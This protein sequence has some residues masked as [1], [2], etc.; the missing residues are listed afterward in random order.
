MIV[1]RFNQWEEF[2][3]E[4]KESPPEGETV[5]LTWNLRYD[6]QG[7]PHLSM[8][9]GYHSGNT[10]VEFV[11]Y[12]GLEPRDRN[13]TRAREIQELFDRRKRCLEALGLRVKPGRYHAP[14]AL[15]R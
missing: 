15:R 7:A 5:R 12:L 10:L 3:G 11:Q 8:I 14:P 4:A 13:G 1:V 2:V 9:A 6:G